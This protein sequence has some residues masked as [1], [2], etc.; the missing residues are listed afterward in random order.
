M[1]KGG[2]RVGKP[3][4]SADFCCLRCLACCLAQQRRTLATTVVADPLLPSPKP[5]ALWCTLVS[6]G[7]ERGG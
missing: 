5:A 3:S 2:A 7:I 4:C 6:E 1:N